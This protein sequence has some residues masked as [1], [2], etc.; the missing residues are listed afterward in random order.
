MIDV[1]KEMEEYAE[2]NNVPI[3]QKDSLKYICDYINE[4][5]LY[6]ILEIGTAIGY[7]TINFALSNENVNITSLERDINRYNEAVKNVQKASLASRIMLINEDALNINITGKFN[8]IIIDAAKGQNI[9][10]FTKYE[11]NLLPGGVIIIDNIKF[12]GLVGN[13][14]DIKSKNLRQL[15]SKIEE[16]ILFLKNKKD[17]NILFVDAGD[18]LAICKK[19]D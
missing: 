17:Y 13:S 19:M 12:H 3:M 16:F 9:N 15:V 18:G 5:N 2:I 1:I 7:S 11:E 14:K 8:L 10:F 6:N 4:N